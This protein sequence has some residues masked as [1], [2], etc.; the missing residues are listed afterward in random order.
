[1]A[2]IVSLE[3]M[4]DRES[5]L[6]RGFGFIEFYNNAAAD[7]AKRHLSKRELRVHDRELLVMWAEPKKQDPTA[8]QVSGWPQRFWTGLDS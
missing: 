2:G 8:E 7:A 3:L 5:G 4:Y 6:A 1:L